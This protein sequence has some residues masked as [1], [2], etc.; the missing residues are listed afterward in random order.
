[1]NTYLKEGDVVVSNKGRDKDK[2][3]LVLSVENNFASIIDGKIH[4]VSK[5]KKKNLKHLSKT[6]DEGKPKF[7]ERI[8]KGESVGNKKLNRALNQNKK[9]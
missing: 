1:M 4:K 3:F 9:S 6:T 7:V 8:K 5:P 2:K